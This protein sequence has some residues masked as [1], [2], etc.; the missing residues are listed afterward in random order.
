[1][2]R[3]LLRYGIRRI[4]FRAVLVGAVV[5]AGTQSFGT[6]TTGHAPLADTNTQGHSADNSGNVPAAAAADGTVDPF[7][8]LVIA[9]EH[10]RDGYDRALFPHWDD[11]NAD[12]CN[13]R[14][15]LLD[16][17]RR[18]DGSWY[19]AWDNTTVTDQPEIHVDHIVALAEAWDS[20]ANTWTP[21]M[22]DDFA[23]DTSNLIL[24]SAVS[25]QSKSDR[26]ASEWFPT[27]PEASCLFAAATVHV[28]ATWALT[29]DP[30]EAAALRNILT[31]CAATD[32]GTAGSQATE[33]DT[34]RVQ[35]ST[36]ADASGQLLVTL[37][38]P[39]DIWGGPPRLGR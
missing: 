4:V 3:T 11:Y 8:G 12:G 35:A 34:S 26:D 22:R 29:V 1:M 13:T 9:A 37:T 20:G 24:A 27:I 19:S 31:G 6:T 18:R 36:V 15:D 39:V 32:N 16:R 33:H 38:D 10:P 28:K 14:C 25:N 2:T 21:Q 23:D 7:L 17:E 30:D 5:A